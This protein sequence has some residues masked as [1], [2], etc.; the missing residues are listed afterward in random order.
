[1]NYVYFVEYGE[2]FT[3]TPNIKGVAAQQPHN[4]VGARG[5]VPQ[6]G[7]CRSSLKRETATLLRSAVFS[8]GERICEVPIWGNSNLK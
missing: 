3:T 1:M 6:K 5:H 7:I 4:M 2:N 8:R